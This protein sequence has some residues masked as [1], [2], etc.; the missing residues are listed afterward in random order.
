MLKNNGSASYLHDEGRLVLTLVQLTE[1]QHAED[2]EN[3]CE[4]IL[5]VHDTRRNVPADSRHSHEQRANFDEEQLMCAH[6]KDRRKP[7]GT[8]RTSENPVGRGRFGS[9]DSSLGSADLFGILKQSQRGGTT[10]NVQTFR[11]PAVTKSE[12]VLD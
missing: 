10:N 1:H 2:S 11:S 6:R 3:S 12:Q 8:D 9:G 5:Q 7:R 4:Q